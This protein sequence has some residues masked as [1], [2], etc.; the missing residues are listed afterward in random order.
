MPPYQTGGDMIEFVYDDRSTW[1]EL[2]HKF[3]AGTPNAADAVG[4]AAACDYLTAIGMP[5]IRAHEV[6]LL[7]AIIDGLSAVEGVTIHGPTSLELKSG[8]VSF[9][10]ADVHPHDLAT[11]L[12]QHGVAIR[13]GHHCCQP[14]MRR[15]DVPATARASVFVY[16]TVSDARALADAVHAAGRVFA[17]G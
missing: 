17:A 9:A 16:S 13:A 10:M 4:L 15:L 3:E 5:A 14:L 8:A 12:D 6:T 7:G 11:I 1:A 2:P